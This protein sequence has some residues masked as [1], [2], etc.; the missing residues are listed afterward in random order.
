MSQTWA[1]AVAAGRR[2][3]SLLPD[4]LAARR[5]LDSTFVRYDWVRIVM[6]AVND[7]DCSAASAC[8]VAESRAEAAVAVHTAAAVELVAAAGRVVVDSNSKPPQQAVARKS[9]AFALC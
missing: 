7:A 8:R 4:P 9:A 5:S 2:S 1:V 3:R 6:S